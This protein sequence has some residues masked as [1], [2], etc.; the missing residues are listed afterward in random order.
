MSKNIYFIS[1]AHL[2]S[3][4]LPHRRMQERRLVRFLDDIKEKAHAIY[5]L[6]DMFDFWYEFKYVV[7]KGY[8]R[9]L[10][11]ISELTDRGIEVHYFTGNHDIWCYD[12]LERECGVV[13]HR[14]PATVELYGQIF[15][16]AHGDGM[17]D[18]SRSFRFLR[19][20]FRNKFCQFCFSLLPTRWSMYLGMSWAKHSMK[21]HLESGI[22]PYQG[23][24]KEHLV[25]YA[26]QYLSKHNSVNYFI[27]GH[28]HI[29]LDLMLSRE[30][31][32][33]IVGDWISQY[34][35]VVFDGCKLLTANYVEGEPTLL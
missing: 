28:R 5:M 14:E 24:E 29:E 9:F 12:Y 7:P 3:L 30:C 2:G 19:S 33:L 18:P 25:Q 16:L 15:Y 20:I 4:A 1:D 32:V 23:E 17:G 35:Y 13:L 34:S 21:G 11:K 10:G 22:V 6:G 8:S 26:K 31:R 27:F